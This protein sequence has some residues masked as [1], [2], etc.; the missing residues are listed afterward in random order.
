MLS[1]GGED[2]TEV[3]EFD[4][5][6]KSFVAGGF[7]LPRSKQ[8]V[9]WLDDDT[10][11]LDR[12]WGPGTMTESGYGFVVKTWKRGQ[13]LDQ[14]TEVFR[15]KPEDVSA[16]PTVMH[17]PQGGRLALIVRAVSFFETETYVVT[18]QGVVKTPL[19]LKHDAAGAARRPAAPHRGAGLDADAGRSRR[20]RRGR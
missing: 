3:R 2:A 15:G 19:P 16:S 10:L 1:D 9:D 14:A 4:P 11:I 6:T 18:A 8:D 5:A 7:R 20:S 12:D 13:A 17:D